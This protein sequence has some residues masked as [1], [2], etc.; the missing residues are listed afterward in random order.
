MRRCRLAYGDMSYAAMRCKD[1][2]VRPKI[3]VA[4]ENTVIDTQQGKVFRCIASPPV[5]VWLFDSAYCA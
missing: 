5:N 3:R 2:V 4:I 1:P